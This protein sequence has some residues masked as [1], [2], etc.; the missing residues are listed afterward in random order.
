MAVI[1]GIAACILIRRRRRQRPS[2]TPGAGDTKG[3]DLYNGKDTSH[4][5]QPL[6]VSRPPLHDTRKI[7]Q[8]Y[9]DTDR[10]SQEDKTSFIELTPTSPYHLHKKP[11]A[12]QEYVSTT[13]GS[14]SFTR[15]NGTGRSGVYVPR[16]S[17]DPVKPD[18]I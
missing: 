1:A 15:N 12:K 17:L 9:H 5:S 3:T 2:S 18:G 11:S 16:F 6:P 4:Y 8:Q 10:Q 14:P 13:P 7:N